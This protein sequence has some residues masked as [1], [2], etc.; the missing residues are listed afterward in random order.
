ML[1]GTGNAQAP[2]ISE[3]IFATN[4]GYCLHMLFF[5]PLSFIIVIII[6]SIFLHTT[7]TIIT[8][9]RNFTLLTILSLITSTDYIAPTFLTI[10]SCNY[11]IL[12]TMIRRLLTK[13]VYFF[14]IT[15][16]YILYIILTTVVPGKAVTNLKR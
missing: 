6:I 8:I 1:L 4:G 11:L 5:F 14:L 10:L 13:K 3:H 12:Q 15:L 2:P 9:L 16:L 7:L